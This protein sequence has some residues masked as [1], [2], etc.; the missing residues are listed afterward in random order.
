MQYKVL[1]RF[2]EPGSDYWTSF[3]SGI[4]EIQAYA[5]DQNWN[6]DPSKGEVSYQYLEMLQEVYKRYI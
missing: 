4:A 1:L 3:G 6:I 2:N 5:L